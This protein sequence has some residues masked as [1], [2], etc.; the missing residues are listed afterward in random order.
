MKYRLNDCVSSK[1]NSKVFMFFHMDLNATRNNGLFNLNNGI[2]SETRDY[3]KW[4]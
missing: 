2:R 4:K 1:I 3:V